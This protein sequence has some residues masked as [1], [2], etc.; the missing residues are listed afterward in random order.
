VARK[1]AGINVV[2]GTVSYN[3]PVNP[4]NEPLAWVP[5]LRLAQLSGVARSTL[6]GWMASGLIQPSSHGAFSA[7]DLF[8]VV[9]VAALRDELPPRAVLRAMDRLRK[10]GQ[11]A[12]LL[13]H[14]AIRGP[15]EPGRIDLVVD[16]HTGDVA[17]C[18]DD[19]ELVAAV[20]G[21]VPVTSMVIP[22]AAELRR[23]RRGFEALAEHGPPPVRR[24]G[25]PPR[26]SAAVTELR[27]V[28]DVPRPR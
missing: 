13:D 1:N 20:R 19:A 17:L 18:T 2:S 26:R 5:E 3:Q 4:E 14:A 15:G 22:I 6:S 11:F 25:R 23:A 7:V 12:R 21:T 8:E 27:A 10:T 16:V 24:R 9:V 28:R